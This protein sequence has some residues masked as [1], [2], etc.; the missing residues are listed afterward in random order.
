[1]TFLAALAARWRR[2]RHRHEWALTGEWFIQLVC[3]TC[4]GRRGPRDRC[5]IEAW[6]GRKVAESI[7]ADRR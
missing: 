4:G 6:Y 1:M 2:L 5:D 7:R 3:L